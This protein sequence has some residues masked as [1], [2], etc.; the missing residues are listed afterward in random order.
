MAATLVFFVGRAEVEQSGAD[1]TL[2]RLTAM[3]T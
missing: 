3:T 2:A 1:G